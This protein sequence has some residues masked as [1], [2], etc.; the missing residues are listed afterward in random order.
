VK[1][2]CVYPIW[3]VDVGRHGD[4]PSTLLKRQGNTL[5]DAPKLWRKMDGNRVVARII[6]EYENCT[7]DMKP[8]RI[9]VDAETLAM[10]REAVTAPVGRPLITD[11]ISN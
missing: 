6:R 10:W 3:G 7:N 5:I 11:V 2:S 9:N 8:K 1:T 4:D